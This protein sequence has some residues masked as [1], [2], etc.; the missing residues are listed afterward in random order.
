MDCSTP[1]LPCGP[2]KQA[3]PKVSCL[4]RWFL[5]L[6][7][8]CFCPQIHRLLWDL[9]LR[10]SKDGI[11]KHGGF[12]FFSADK[13]FFS[14]NSYFKW[15]PSDAADWR[16]VSR[17]YMIGDRER[18]Q[19]TPSWGWETAPLRGSSRRASDQAARLKGVQQLTPGVFIPRSK[20]A[21]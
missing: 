21:S 11:M 19:F 5:A 14:I 4:W 7:F 2:S 9:P 12:C 10:V 20:G 16:S 8:P 3:L 17:F 18:I 6:R 15:T 1:A 13:S